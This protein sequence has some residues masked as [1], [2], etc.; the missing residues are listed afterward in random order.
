M[1]FPYVHGRLDPRRSL[2]WERFLPSKSM[3]IKP[4][5]GLDVISAEAGYIPHALSRDANDALLNA[6]KTILFGVSFEQRLDFVIEN[7]VTMQQYL[8]DLALR[9]S[10]FFGDSSGRLKEGRHGLN[11]HLSNL[12]SS[13]RLYRDHTGHALSEQFGKNS[14]AYQHYELEKSQVYDTSLGYRCL[15]VL[16]N[17]AQHRGLPAHSITFRSVHDEKEQ[18]EVTELI[19][20][21]TRH[22][23]AFSLIPEKLR[24][25]GGFKSSVLQE[26]ERSTDKNGRID[27]MPLIRD[28]VSGIARIHQSIRMVRIG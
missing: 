6:R 4:I 26:L 19:K 13:A 8:L 22:F 14:T 16:R 17:Y 5:Y 25:D 10:V 28:Y 24:L 21:R 11:R 27:L 2:P 1:N 23:V 7:Y 12:L 15:E 9:N 20:E 18:T 3:S